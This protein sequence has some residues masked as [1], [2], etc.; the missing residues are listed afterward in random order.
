LLAACSAAPEPPFCS[1]D[2]VDYSF[3]SLVSETIEYS[4]RVNE[5]ID[6][7]TDMPYEPNESDNTY[8]TVG[9]I[10][11]RTVNDFENSVWKM[12]FAKITDTDARL[13]QDM[14]VAYKTENGET[15]VYDTMHSETVFQAFG[16]VGTPLLPSN[17]Q[18]EMLYGR[19]DGDRLRYK[20]KKDSYSYAFDY[21]D[22]KGSYKLYDKAA[23]ALAAD[24]TGLTV[25]T[26]K[27]ASV[28]DNEQLFYLLTAAVSRIKKG[29]T[30]TTAQSFKLY[31]V[32]DDVANN[33]GIAAFSFATGDNTGGYTNHLPAEF[34]DVKTDGANIA[35][36]Y[37]GYPLGNSYAAF[38]GGYID[39]YYLTGDKPL[40]VDG[41]T[42][43][44][45]AFRLIGYRQEISN[46]QGQKLYGLQFVLKSYE[47]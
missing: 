42:V 16:T 10:T 9:G 34:G 18:K 8:H 26:K 23:G 13:T 30:A 7:A 39:A 31:S 12:Q 43:S 1:I 37:A 5:Y 17:V 19:A 35:R 27:L 40:T 33:A 47:R 20:T 36:V 29:D 46:S 32:Y 38:Q 44:L 22:G 21:T 41:Q 3:V 14:T 15:A 25:K 24:P 6:P 28:Y 45:P 2:T 4:V 11:Y